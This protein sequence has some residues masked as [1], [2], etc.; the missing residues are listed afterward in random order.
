[1]E[2]RIK[3]FWAAGFSDLP[4]INATVFTTFFQWMSKQLQNI[5]KPKLFIYER[6]LAVQ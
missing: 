5:E 6:P 3:F 1:M 4:A 2:K